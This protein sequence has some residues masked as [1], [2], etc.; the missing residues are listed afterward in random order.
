MPLALPRF[1]RPS[2]QS[3]LCFIHSHTV[4]T[5]T[6]LEQPGNTSFRH[7]QPL[8]RYHVEKVLVWIVF[9]L[10]SCGAWRLCQSPGSTHG[11][12]SL[13]ALVRRGYCL[14]PTS[15]TLRPGRMMETSAPTFCGWCCHGR[16]V[17]MVV[18]ESL[19]VLL[20]D[21]MKTTKFS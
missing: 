21:N 19:H 1:A 7:V 3:Q 8:L 6:T 12:P 9:L 2:R 10:C 17:V 15:V 14:G 18:S 20:S 4:S 11:L 13:T 16:H 5:A